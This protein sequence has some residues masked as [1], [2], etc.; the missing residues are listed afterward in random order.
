MPRKS[1]TL[2]P[3]E[4]ASED[5]NNIFKQRTTLKERMEISKRQCMSLERFIEVF[6]GFNYLDNRKYMGDNLLKNR[7]LM[8]LVSANMDLMETNNEKVWKLG[9]AGTKTGKPL[10]RLKD[11]LRFYGLN[12]KRKPHKGVMIFMCLVTNFT[13][14]G[15]GGTAASNSLIHILER[16]LKRKLKPLINNLNKEDARGSERFM[17]TQEDVIGE[18]KAM[19]KGRK[20]IVQYSGIRT[21]SRQKLADKLGYINIKTGRLKLKEIKCVKTI[22]QFTFKAGER[23]VTIPPGR[24]FHIKKKRDHIELRS[25]GR[26]KKTYM[27]DETDVNNPEIFRNDPYCGK[28]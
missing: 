11:Y 19:V 15:Q 18:I 7:R 27:L 17:M 21:R 10:S 9:I 14:T 25:K 16:D 3:L 13:R 8:Y 6:S 20:D 28:H 4:D 5:V 2:F 24:S 23:D 26:R 1:Q 22:K 12:D